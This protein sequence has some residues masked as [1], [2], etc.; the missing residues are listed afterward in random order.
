MNWAVEEL[1]KINSNSNVKCVRCKAIFPEEY[2]KCP[3]CE[4]KE[5]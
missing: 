4:A 1:D 2:D 5:L 3:Q